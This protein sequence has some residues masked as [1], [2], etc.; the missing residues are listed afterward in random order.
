MTISAKFIPNGPLN[1]ILAL[2]QIMAWRR[3][4]N[5]ALSELLVIIYL[6]HIC[7]TR[8]KYGLGACWMS[9]RC[10]N[11]CWLVLNWTIG[12]K[13][14]WN[15][16]KN[17][18][19]QGE[20]SDNVVCKMAAI[21]FRPQYGNIYFFEKNTRNLLPFSCQKR[22]MKANFYSKNNSVTCHYTYIDIDLD[23]LKS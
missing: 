19:I 8:H 13:F 14:Q 18:T 6:K 22:N 20:K 16:I 2:V 7:V 21:L 4:G 23:A 1:N 17:T 9:N 15:L 12:N 5:K 3:P 11:Q 10:V